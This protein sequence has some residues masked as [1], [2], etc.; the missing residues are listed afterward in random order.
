LPVLLA[1]CALPLLANATDLSHFVPQ[2]EAK[3]VRQVT[4]NFSQAVRPLG[5]LAA[6][7][8]MTWTC[9]G[10]TLKGRGRWVDTQ[11]W[12]LDFERELP[13]GVRCEFKPASPLRDLAGTSIKAA[14]VYRFDTGGP[15]IADINSGRGYGDIDEDAVFLVAATG[16]L[17]FASIE[18]NAWCA[19]EGLGEKVPVKLLPDAEKKTLLSRDGRQPQPDELARS[20]AL[21]CARQLPNGA[22][23]RLFWGTGIKGSTGLAT[24]QA[25]SREFKVRPE[26]TVTV[27]CERENAKADCVPMTPIVLRFTAAVRRDDVMKMRLTGPGGRKWS[28]TVADDDGESEFVDYVQFIGPFPA[29]ARFALQVPE[30]I[31]DEAG[32]TLTNR[33]R[34]AKVEL[35]TAAYPPLVKFAADFGIVERKAGG[36]LP[37]TL[38]NLE[39]VADGTLPTADNSKPGTAATVRLLRLTRDEDILDWLRRANQSRG[40]DDRRVSLLKGEAGVRR[41][42]LPKPNGPKPM[43]VVGIPLGEPGQYVVEAESKQLGEHLLEPPAPMYVRTL[44]LNTNL[45]VHFKKG[46]ENSLVWVT[47]LDAGQPVDKARVVLRTCDGKQVAFG[48]TGADGTLAIR[49]RLPEQPKGCSG[50]WNYFVSARANV[51]GV[52][53][54]GFATSDWQKGIERW[55]FKLPYPTAVPDVMTHT[56]FDRP[57]FRTG[58]TVHMKHLARRHT[59]AGFAYARRE[60]LPERIAIQLEGSDIRY[61]LPLA[62]K[63][64]VAESTWT[65]PAEAK[66]GRYWIAFLRASDKAGRVS[67]GDMGD[68]DGE[69]AWIDP[70][71]YWS[72]GSFKV[73]EFR[74]P[75]MRGEVAG[76][77]QPVVAA[78]SLA[79]DLR[80]GYL[81]GGAASGE[82]VRVRSEMRPASLKLPDGME[83]Y[84]FG[85]PPV[86][87]A[88]IKAGGGYGGAPEAAVFDDQRDVALDKTGTR[89]LAIAE[90]PQWPVPATVFTEME[91][92]DPSGETHAAAGSSA[93]FP[94]ATLI[95]LASEGWGSN[96][97]QVRLKLAT[98]D[99]AM[100]P[101]GSLAYSVRGW[102]KRS[103]VHRKRLVGGFYSYDT[104]YD[105]IEL[106]ELCKGLSD[107]KGAA[108]CAFKPPKDEKQ[109]RGG[110]LILEARAMDAAGRPSYAVTSVWLGDNDEMWFEQDESDRIDVLPDKKRYEPGDTAVLQVRMP[111]RQATALVSVEREGIIDRFVTP[112][113]GRDPTLRVPIKA[114]YGPNAF[115]SVFVVRGRVG[116][117]QPTALVDLG[118]PAYKLGIAEI[119]VGQ[120]GYELAVKVDTDK[121]VYKTREDVTARVHVSRPD[122]TPA[123]G[124]E[125]ALAAVDE[126]LLELARNDSWQLLARMMARRGYGVETATAQAQVIGK[127]HFGLK[128]LPAGGG[129]GR[130]PTR[131]LFDTLIKWEGR[132]VLDDNGE[133]TVK[134][135]LSDALTTIRIVA[136]AQQ[137]TSLF[138]TGFA[139][140]RTSKDVQLFAGLP[141][142][143]REGDQLR[144]GFTLRNLTQAK[145]SFTVTPSGAALVDGKRVPLAALAA[146]TV[147]LDAGEARELG[148]PLTVP[149]AASRLDWQVSARSERGAGQDALRVTQN[150]TTALPVRVQAATLE[151]VSGQLTVPVK[152]PAGAESGRGSVDVFLKPTLGA[153][154]DGVKAYMESYPYVCLEQ[155]VSK[156]LGT[157]SQTRW[158][159]IAGRLPTYLDPD[160]LAAYFTNPERGK[161][162]VALTAYLLA[163]SNEGGYS[164]PDE[165]RERMLGALAAFVEG[166]LKDDARN[167][168]SPKPDLPVR[169]LMA[170]EALSRYGRAT[171]Q[172]LATVPITPG[173]WPTGAVVDWFNIVNRLGNL[174][175]RDKQLAEA[176][177]MLRTRMVASGTLTQFNNEANDY[178]WWLMVSPDS[179][180]ARAISALM[181]RP[182]WQ[183]EIPRLVRGVMARQHE[184]HWNTTPAN[185]WGVLMLDKFARKFESEPVTGATRVTLAGSATP[186]QA[187]DW[188]KLPAVDAAKAQA[189]ATG[190]VAVPEAGAAWRDAGERF[191]FA[192]PASGAGSVG[193]EQQGSGKPWATV[194]VRAA[195]ALTTPLYAGFE[196]KKTVTPVEQKV[197]GRWSRGDILEVRMDIKAPTTWTWVVVNDP[198]PAGATI[199]GSGLGRESQLATSGAG[200]TGDWASFIERAFD[201]YRAY[202]E[203]FSGKTTVVYR[204]R[205]NNSG[206]FQLPP[207]RVEAMYAPENFGEVPN[208]AL[209]VD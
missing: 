137:G 139:R 180:A 175:N 119:A 81:A 116:D 60:A 59:T 51:D 61:E 11:S 108:S 42:L 69:D 106:G 91:Y 86:D 200:N 173:L 122:G 181:D 14:P 194:Q 45:A 77:A 148:W 19:I 206:R 201:G 23:V 95:G 159:D 186:A 88:S 101:L 63:N 93:W 85:S 75:V 99:P 113:S 191:R 167:Y 9:Q 209:S 138:G 140:I 153:S 161:G 24:T 74:L 2:G 48:S 127:R 104:R 174:P 204:Y 62:W 15:N 197:K 56:V 171:P 66:L 162:S 65:I 5:D 120:K 202:Y 149:L 49:R 89:R 12:V 176:E 141:P 144:A 129:G 64:G 179:T 165:P 13:A 195:R 130:Q 90:L 7:D 55:R 135:P 80:L 46:D 125:F 10:T 193:I 52:E 107:G 43:E 196:V 38:R 97:E 132:V 160:G 126:A 112:I 16:P 118:K 98:L 123:K 109:Q 198:V 168:W 25:E 154:S 190:K 208:E 205:L 53:D 156:A 35:K 124:G 72:G 178:W 145:D 87:P 78:K 36:L 183:R 102:Y 31:R 21:R 164:L 41:A 169:K 115:I 105:T 151:Q 84:V 136:V 3:R 150:V 8:P 73:G 158:A 17:D 82:K 44:A 22:K 70:G 71:R 185:V 50:F 67:A 29:E 128:A 184:G 34:L 131:E 18:A 163:V 207:T 28:A 83:S 142:L 47:T 20:A 6:A 32:R 133:A 134:L 152:L 4:V 92:S 30:R 26:F 39:P 103:F 40:Y 147:T 57:L 189:V 121:P 111:F 155:K 143:V 76:A 114:N 110:E 27:N 170:I 166:R 100:Q 96:A 188:S 199:L 203:T 79:V 172:Q 1:A 94:S 33:D 146:Q 182:A 58:E 117:V 37:A 177:A 157:G 187:L 68:G 54:I 192:W